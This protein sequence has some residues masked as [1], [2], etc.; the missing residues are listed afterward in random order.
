VSF[1]PFIVPVGVSEDTTNK[2]SFAIETEFSMIG[3][4]YNVYV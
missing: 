1:Y 3:V 2:E 4:F